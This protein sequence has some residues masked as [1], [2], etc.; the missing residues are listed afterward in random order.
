M[1]ANSRSSREVAYDT[2]M[3]FGYE[4]RSALRELGSRRVAAEH[5]DSVGDVY[6]LTCAELLAMP[7]DAR[8][9]VKRRRAERERLQALRLPEVI[10]RRWTPL[11][12]RG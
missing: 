1:A 5:I 2:T 11:D 4:F 8:L 7:S 6:F 12:G 3:R 10:D 9:R